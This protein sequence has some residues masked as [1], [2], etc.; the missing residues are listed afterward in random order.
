M[1][2]R[3]YYLGDVWIVI[4]FSGTA[5]ACFVLAPLIGKALGWTASD[6]DRVDAIIRA[7]AT[8]ISSAVLVLAFSLVQVHGNLRKT[9]DDRDGVIGR[10]DILDRRL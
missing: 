9:D 6:K 8:I 5:V 3:L 2:D 10:D 4:L 1:L 7:Q